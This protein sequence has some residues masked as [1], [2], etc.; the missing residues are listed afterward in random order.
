MSIPRFCEAAKTLG[1]TLDRI[2]IKRVLDGVSGHR[3]SVDFALSIAAATGGEV[4]FGLWSSTTLRATG[5]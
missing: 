1:L 3:V 4:P 2:A 5:T